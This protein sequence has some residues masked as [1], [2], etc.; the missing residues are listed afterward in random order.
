MAWV[1][2]PQT[3]SPDADWPA[4]CDGFTPVHVAAVR[5]DERMARSLLQA[6]LEARAN[7]APAYTPGAPGSSGFL[8]GILYGF[9]CLGR[10][11]ARLL[12]SRTP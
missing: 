7:I 6:Y 4:V 8:H 9:I 5:G 1:V 11:G 12:A 3:E 2:C 10:F